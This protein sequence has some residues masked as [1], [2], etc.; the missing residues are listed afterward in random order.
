M[1]KMASVR[2]ATTVKYKFPVLFAKIKMYP[3]FIM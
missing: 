2:N 3:Y 1:D